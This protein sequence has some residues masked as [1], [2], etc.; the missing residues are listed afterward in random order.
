MQPKL[1]KTSSQETGASGNNIEKEPQKPHPRL[2]KY[3]YEKSCREYWLCL[4][5]KF[6]NF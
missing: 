3:I 2:E 6:L 5:D 1:I 4:P